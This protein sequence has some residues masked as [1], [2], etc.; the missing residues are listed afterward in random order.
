MEEDTIIIKKIFI[1][2][3][4]I[5]KSLVKN[6]LYN[7][8][9]NTLSNKIYK[10]KKIHYKV[11]NLLNKIENISKDYKNDKIFNLSYQQFNQ[12]NIK[13]N[14]N[15]NNFNKKWI[16]PMVNEKKTLNQNT[17]LLYK[18]KNYIINSSDLLLTY[19]NGEIKYNSEFFEDY[20]TQNFFED[21]NTIEYQ[22]QPVCLLGNSAFEEV[23]VSNENDSI[24]NIENPSEKTKTNSNCKVLR[25]PENETDMKYIYSENKLKKIGL[26]DTKTYQKEIKST[27]NEIR[28]VLKN[29]N[30]N[31]KKFLILNPLKLLH[32]NYNISL[33]NTISYL[34]D[35]IYRT[36]IN[37]D[38]IIN[39]NPQTLDRLNTFEN[40]DIDYYTVDKKDFNNEYSNE[41]GYLFDYLKIIKNLKNYDNIYSIRILKYI[42][43]IF[44]YDLNKIPYCYINYLQSILQNNINSYIDKHSTLNLKIFEAFKTYK[45]VENITPEIVEYIKKL[46]NISSLSYNSNDSIY[47]ILYVNTFDKGLLYYLEMYSNTYVDEEESQKIPLINNIEKIPESDLCKKYKIV[48]IYNS[49][50]EFDEDEYKMVD[51]H[52]SEE[53]YL[54]EY[55]DFMYLL[56]QQ[57]NNINELIFPAFIVNKTVKIDLATN[58]LD[59]DKYKKDDIIELTSENSTE[60]IEFINQNKLYLYQLLLNKNMLDEDIIYNKVIAFKYKNKHFVQIPYQKMSSN[61]IILFLDTNKLYSYDDSSNSLNELPSNINANN[62]YKQIINNCKDSHLNKI[63][64]ENIE[65]IN[66]FYTKLNKT[67]LDSFNRTLNR[68]RMNLSNKLTFYNDILYKTQTT[69]Q[70]DIYFKAI[71]PLHYYINNLN[72]E[73]LLAFL[74]KKTKNTSATFTKTQLIDT[75]NKSPFSSEYIEK[76]KITDQLISEIDK[77]NS[78]K[79]WTSTH[80][81]INDYELLSLVIENGENYNRAYYKLWELLLNDE[82]IFKKDFHLISLAEAPGNFVK[83]VQSLLPKSWLDYIIC[84][85]LDDKETTG[86]NDFFEKYKNNIFGYKKGSLKIVENPGYNGDLTNPQEIDTFIEFINS[87]DKLA[88]LITADGGMD[89]K[90][91]EDYMFEEYNHLPLFLGETIVALFT[92]KIGGTFVLKMYDTLY[93]NSV[94]LLHILS[95]FYE[96]V[97]IIKPYTSRPCN[98]EKYIKCINFT[99]IPNDNKTVLKTNLLNI[100]SDLNK[101]KKDKYIYFDMLDGLTAQ[102]N[103]NNNNEKIKDFNSGIVVKTRALYTEHIYDILVR[104]DEEEIKLIKTYFGKNTTNL[105]VILASDDNETKGFFV[106]KIEKC[107]RLALSLRLNNQPLKQEYIEFYKLIKTFKNKSRNINIYP[108][109]FAEIKKIE[110]DEN[111][112]SRTNSIVNF[113][114]KYCIAFTTPNEHKL[115]DQQILF[116]VEHFI[117]DN[118]ITNIKHNTLQKIKLHR[119]DLHNLYPLLKDMCRLN[120]ISKEFNLYY[121]NNIVISLIRNFQNNIR[122]ILGFYLC[123][124]TYIPIFPKYKVYEN[125]EDQIKECGIRYNSHYI[126]TYSGDKLDKEEFDDFMGDNIHRSLNVDINFD[127]IS[128]DEDSNIQDKSTSNCIILDTPQKKI[129]AYILKLFKIED[130]V[131]MDVVSL[132][133]FFNFDELDVIVSEVNENYEKY[134][135]NIIEQFD[136]I[137]VRYSPEK[138]IKTNNNKQ[139]I[140]FINN[141]LKT[142]KKQNYFHFKDTDIDSGLLKYKKMITTYK[143]LFPNNPD[144]NIKESDDFN[145]VHPLILHLVELLLLKQVYTDYINVIIYTLVQISRINKINFEAVYKV[146]NSKMDKLIKHIYNDISYPYEKFLDNLYA[147]YREKINLPDEINEDTTLDSIKDINVPATNALLEYHINSEKTNWRGNKTENYTKLKSSK[148]II[149]FLN[150]IKIDNIDKHRLKLKLVILFNTDK[151]NKDKMFKKKF[152]LN[153]SDYFDVDV[154]KYLFELSYEKINMNYVFNQINNINNSIFPNREPLSSLSILSYE[155]NRYVLQPDYDSTIFD[156]LELN[157]KTF[158]NKFKLLFLYVYEDENS[159][160]Y[161]YK[162]LYEYDETTNLYKCKYTQNTKTTILNMINLLS[163]EDINTIYNNILIKNQY[164]QNNPDFVNYNT[165]QKPDLSPVSSLINNVLYNIKNYDIDLFYKY[166]TLFYNSQ[167][168]TALSLTVNYKLKNILMRFYNDPIDNIITILNIE[169]IR[170]KLFEFIRASSKNQKSTEFINLLESL[171]NNYDVVLHKIIFNL[172]CDNIKSINSKLNGE[173]DN[174]IKLI[175][176][177][178]IEQ[179]E[180]TLSIQE[181]ISI[182]NTIKKQLGYLCNLSSYNNNLDRNDIFKNL[183]SKF[184]NN[185]RYLYDTNE[186]EKLIKLVQTTFFDYD[187]SEF[188]IHQMQIIYSDILHNFNYNLQNIFCENTFTMVFKKTILFKLISSISTSINKLNSDESEFIIPPHLQHKF[189]LHI[190]DEN[191]IE[192]DKSKLENT[193]LEQQSITNIDKK[194]KNLFILIVNMSIKKATDYNK[195]LYNIGNIVLDDDGKDSADYE[196]GELYENELAPAEED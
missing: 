109:H 14:Y 62:I 187:L 56:Q 37:I 90:T 15:K 174:Y 92:Q 94:N 86:Q 167:D 178:N 8:L 10:T 126:C 140:Q 46:Y 137:F 88:D 61:N 183:K 156:K 168:S 147:N 53:N 59:K 9:L 31:I 7:L 82:I 107:I 117:L 78:P 148:K 20:P 188:D 177:H 74:S 91:D 176:I 93:I 124:Y 186:Y 125:V 171:Q 145:E 193:T 163:T 122:N 47:N 43:N 141:N 120:D 191:K 38:T 95:A 3:Y 180:D 5:N 123:K 65:N 165:Y 133:E 60:F 121:D 181:I 131:Q 106:K 42:Y 85:K 50:T 153:F 55:D 98:S 134:I 13:T 57:L 146:F 112:S 87:T 127:N 24:Y 104:K 63:Q 16:I 71:P 17:V 21:S 79:L 89:K 28:N 45:E 151:I 30:I 110:S 113:V 185:I 152:N 158:Y 100:L 41:N 36:H 142:P 97:K 39:N 12:F 192:I 159:P 138:K 70:S 115:L 77:T 67:N 130:N 80:H 119:N 101:S 35:I 29:E 23:F 149:D 18:Y 83:C 25:I 34:N 54:I 32:T 128:L 129:C 19:E 49:Q 143:T 26:P 99:G 51:K 114:K 190:N 135:N 2:D 155:K 132:L 157:D 160:F 144:K 48:K 81:Y 11:T 102:I 162:R 72:K 64:I 103:L 1:N 44:G 108:P 182:F 111:I 194:Y 118:N 52:Y 154:F 40:T 150:N 139:P 22:K 73:I 69:I 84:T 195:I 164:I 33:G 96:T 76:V 175:N 68:K 161:G 172:N 75:L 179:F 66:K 105:K 189:Y 136:A 173:L 184:S 170:M 116:L 6:S 196:Q 58:K 4:I 169:T 166:L 27:F